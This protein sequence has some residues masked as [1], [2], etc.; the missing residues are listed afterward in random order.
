MKMNRRKKIYSYQRECYH[1]RRCLALL[2]AIMGVTLLVSLCLVPAVP[3]LEIPTQN[4]DL[5]I[6]WDNTLK[7][8]TALRLEDQSNT[9]ISDP[10]QDDGIM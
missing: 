5:L 1:G 9:L 2:H 8:S 4:P 6:R 3:A 7:Y 10:N